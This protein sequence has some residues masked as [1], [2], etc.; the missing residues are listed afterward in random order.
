[1]MKVTKRASLAE[2]MAI[3]KAL[4]A[5]LEP[6]AGEEPGRDKMRFKLGHSHATVMASLAAAGVQVNRNHVEYVRRELHGKLA[7][8]SDKGIPRPGRS[9]AAQGRE[10]M[11]HSIAQL[12]ARIEAI[13]NFLT[14]SD[15][16]KGFKPAGNKLL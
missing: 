15:Y 4:D 7:Q 13:E 6:A 10:E 2:Q 3:S 12:E 1:M 5:A 16:A 11:R 8:R 9:P 14:G